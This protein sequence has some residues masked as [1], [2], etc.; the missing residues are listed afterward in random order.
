M[1]ELA[2]TTLSEAEMFNVINA[3][4]ITSAPSDLIPHWGQATAPIGAF[5]IRKIGSM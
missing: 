2:E 3:S 5:F 1:F 4:R